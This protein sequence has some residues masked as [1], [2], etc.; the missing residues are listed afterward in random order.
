MTQEILS[1]QHALQRPSISKMIK[2]G[3]R[4]AFIVLR[5]LSWSI[6]K[7]QQRKYLL[8]MSDSQLADIGVSRQE[9]I[10][11]ANKQLWQ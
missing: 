1:S 10:A 5:T 8:T 4:S 3:S 2:Y 9:A 11:E 6:R 7:H